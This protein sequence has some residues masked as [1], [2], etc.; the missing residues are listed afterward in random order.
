MQ[1]QTY[2]SRWVCGMNGLDAASCS[3]FHN[4]AKYV[5]WL[6]CEKD[7]LKTPSASENPTERG[8]ATP[9]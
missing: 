1:R 2:I 8:S 7:G 5:S 6:C 4:E 3:V 9:R